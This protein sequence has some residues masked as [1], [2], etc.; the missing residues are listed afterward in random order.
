MHYLAQM[1]IEATDFATDQAIG[2]A[3]SNHHRSDCCIVIAHYFARSA[4]RH[5]V[6]AYCFMVE[7]GEAIVLL[8]SQR[9]EHFHFVVEVDA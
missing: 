1:K 3:S 6:T 7:R 5:T 8:V 2:V 9:V 4:D